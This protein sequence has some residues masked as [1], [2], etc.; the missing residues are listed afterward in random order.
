M[1]IEPSEVFKERASTEAWR[2]TI[3]SYAQWVSNQ[4]RDLIDWKPYW[5][6][7]NICGYLQSGF[8]EGAGRNMVSMPPQHGKS[9]LLAQWLPIWFLERNPR[10]N[11][12]Y[13]TYNNTFAKQQGEEVRNKA[14]KDIVGFE[15]SSETKSKNRFKTKKGGEYFSTGIEGFGG[16]VRGDMIIIDDPYK[17]YEEAQ[18]ESKREAVI[19]SYTN[20]IGPRLT[21]EANTI[22]LHTRWHS[23]DLIGWLLDR[24]SDKWD[25][26]RYPAI[27]DEVAK[28][29][30]D[31][32][33]NPDD[34]REKGEPLNPDLKGKDF[35][36]ERKD[37]LTK[38]EWKALYQQ[39]PPDVGK[40]SKLWSDRII[41]ENRIN[42]GK[43][44]EVDFKRI[45]V[46]I[47]PAGGGKDETGIVVVGIDYDGIIYVLEDRSGDYTPS[48]WGAEAREA[49]LEWEADRIVAE[50]NYGGNMVKE[51]IRQAERGESLPYD[52]VNAKKGKRLRAEPVA[53]KYEDDEIKHA[54]EFPE[55]ERQMTSFKTGQRD[56]PDRMD[57][58]VYGCTH[59]DRGG[60]VWVM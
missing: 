9:M 43:L 55:L 8:A 39:Q 58:L 42:P 31:Y 28:G 47:D 29:A 53:A 18:R 4:Y 1:A 59:V 44:E 51:V 52:S 3:L 56:S 24:K 17:N 26:H 33:R 40:A 14:R 16:G 21:T 23:N 10:K 37:E 13:I 20:D 32:M 50:K 5:Y 41:E 15:L 60:G 6:L 48:E 38:P 11:V 30:S 49:Y 45:V 34:K 57:A 46:A 35:L 22:I 12:L 19:K 27:K 7:E 2:S 25:Y 36:L 54:G